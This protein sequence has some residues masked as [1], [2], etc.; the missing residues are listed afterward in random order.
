MAAEDQKEL[1][2]S[3]LKVR[4]QSST[5]GSNSSKKE[6]M[7]IINKGTAEEE[8]RHETM[9]IIIIISGHGR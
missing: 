5:R 7:S 3:N 1:V 2:G 6:I 8:A 9:E 4:E